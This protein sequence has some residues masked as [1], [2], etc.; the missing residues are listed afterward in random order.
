M[1]LQLASLMVIAVAVL[2]CIV[3]SLRFAG[4]Q[5]WLLAVGQV[6][7]GAALALVLYP[8]SI[9]H[10]RETAV[11]L[12]EGVTPGQLEGIEQGITL[13]ALPE[14]PTE[15]DHAERAVD[16]GSALRQHPEIGD[17][18]IL[19]DGLPAR[20]RDAVA[21]L[22][23]AFKPVEEPTGLVEL[24]VPDT[25]NAGTRWALSGRVAGS[26]QARVELLDRSDAVVAST[27]I[28]DD[29]RFRL[30][31]TAKSNTRMLYRLRVLDSSDTLIEEVPVAV[32]ARAG[33]TLRTLIVAGAPDAELKYLRRWIVDA[34]HSLGSQIALSRGIEQRQS[35]GELDPA[36]LA[37][38]DLLIVDERSW[39][40]FSQSTRAAVREAVESGMGLLLRVTG[41]VPKTVVEDWLAM[42]FTLEEKDVAR[43]VSLVEPF[44]GADGSRTITRQPVEVTAKDSVAL[45][46]AGDDSDLA[47]WRAVGLGRVGIWLPLDTWRMTLDGDREGYGTLWSKVFST[48]ARARSAATPLLPRQVRIH[49]RS[50]ICGLQ[51]GAT[52]EGADG[53]RHDLLVGND[54]ASC[55]AWWPTEAGWHELTNA[56]ERWPMHV[57]DQ[58]EAVALQ[59]MQLREATMALVRDASTVQRVSSELPRWPFFLVWL[60]LAA[61][62]WWL[63]RRR[64]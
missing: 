49:Q 35:A 13:I 2:F 7:M 50:V 51:P 60:T 56:D 36:T 18:L 1:S 52:I 55:A 57:L 17:V 39:G 24:L 32:V 62:V 37:E 23:V 59:R 44:D 47:I 42:G 25:V 33:D 5:R 63:E 45:V 15:F 11:V 12:T 46:K 40:A 48:L 34:G 30:S 21:E 54:E 20:D 26:K 61:L 43:S 10:D 27:A 19:G 31:A 3:R 41:P 28:D 53:V 6:L 9:P 4:K 16:L 38:T 29:G 22:G 58:G 8:P 14:A 64:R